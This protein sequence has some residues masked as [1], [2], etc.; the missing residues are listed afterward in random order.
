MPLELNTYAPHRRPLFLLRKLVTT[1]PVMQTLFGQ[2]HRSIPLQL[3]GGHS[4]EPNERNR[5]Q[6]LGLGRSRVLQCGHPQ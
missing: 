3:D 4:T 2:I 1:R 6:Y 5:Q